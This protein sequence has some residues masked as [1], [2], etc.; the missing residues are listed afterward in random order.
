MEII[1]HGNTANNYTCSCGCE[2]IASKIDRRIEQNFYLHKIRYYVSCPECGK[3]VEDSY[4][5]W[6]YA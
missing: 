6:E 2:F 4:T 1:K 3:K 5:K